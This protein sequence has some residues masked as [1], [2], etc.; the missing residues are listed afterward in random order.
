MPFSLTLIIF[1]FW[2]KVRDMKLFHSVEHLEAI[3]E[4]L[5]GLISTFLYLREQEGQR[6][7]RDMQE[8]LVSG[9]VRM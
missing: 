1:S 4:L 9:I 8:K 7:G 6:R 3:I 2:F 5:I